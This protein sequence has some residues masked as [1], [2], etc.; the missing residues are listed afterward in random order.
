MDARHLDLLTK[1]LAA[2]PSRRTALRFLGAVLLSSSVGQGAPSAEAACIAPGAKGKCKKSEQCCTGRC[3]KKHRKCLP[4]ATGTT[5]CAAT[6]A[7]EEPGAC[8]CPHGQESCNGGCVTAGECPCPDGTERCN[9]GCVAAGEC[10]CPEGKV[11]C[12]GACIAAESE[13]CAPTASA[14]QAALG[15]GGTDTIRLCPDTTYRGLLRIARDVTVVGAGPGSTTLDGD[16]GPATIVVVGGATVELRG[17]RITSPSYGVQN[18]GALTLAGVRLEGNGNSWPS[19]ILNV[20]ALTLID[21][22]VSG[23]SGD[24]GQLGSR[25][26]DGGGI[27]NHPGAEVTLRRST[28]SGNKAFKGGGIYNFR[29]VVTI[30]EDSSVSNNVAAFGGGIGQEGGTIV[31]KSGG[32]VSGN[33]ATVVGGI[34]N[35][36][37]T[38]TLEDGG[39]VSGNTASQISGGVDNRGTL[40]LW[41]GSRVSGNS[42]GTYGGGISN[43]G[44][45]TLED[46]SRV[47]DNTAGSMGGGIANLGRATLKQGSV[48][49]HNAAADGGGISNGDFA[50]LSLE[51]GSRVTDNTADVGGGISDDSGGG[52]TIAADDIVTGNHLFDGTTLTNCSP[53]NSIPNCVG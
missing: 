4:C 39:V 26:S 36:E 16:G 48:V 32:R 46:G 1:R 33:T 53:A 24:T 52:V 25:V 9:G 19:G 2:R 29:G 51:A 34:D 41:G 11:K 47:A 37:G 40:T 8:P 31:V 42:A 17:L 3:N 20:G 23:F 38:V 35:Y 50:V 43:F 6:T 27:N 15:P 13:C 5:Y 30:G 21:S 22:S 49:A 7:C 12:Y 18:F 45:L 44:T 28:V 14:V 10:P